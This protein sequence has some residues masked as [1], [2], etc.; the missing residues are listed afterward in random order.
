[1]ETRAHHLLIGSFL[2]LFLLGILGFALWLA[3][4]QLDREIARYNI[5]FTGSVAGLG[6][7]GD[8]RFN[9]I[10]IGNVSQISIDR[11]DTAKVRVTVNVAADT[12]IR[13][14]S[15]AS[16]ELQGI[17]GVSF[18][19]ISAGTKGAELLPARYSEDVSE[20]PVIR[21]RNSSIAELFEAAPDLV[22]RAA[23]IMSDQNIENIGGIIGDIR[24]LTI[25]L[26]SRQETLTRA[27]DGF[28]RT[29]ADIAIA[30]RAARDVAEQFGGIVKEANSTL[31]AARNTLE[32]TTKLIEGDATATVKDAQVA[33]QDIRGA[34]QQLDA[35]L[36]TVNEMVA[37]NRAPINAITTDGFGEFRR[38]IAE[39]RILVGSLARVA[40]R[41]EDD[42]S[43]V[44][45]G[46]RDAE[47]RSE[48]GR[49]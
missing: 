11:E 4:A 23:R 30:A 18:V 22:N 49:R 3:K 10:K 8:V 48:G 14:D 13:G 34:M 27:I 5:F 15:V 46:N 12:P 1:M 26:A 25:T 47:Y 36:S 43:A 31:V 40:Q 33:V 38:F 42:P 45:F 41:L 6:Q 28:D 20:L 37:E 21:S 2:L 29:S 32:A 24:Q 35:V 19:Q 17:T 44:L 7:G 9:G 16:L 39:A